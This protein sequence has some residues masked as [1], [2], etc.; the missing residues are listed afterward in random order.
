MKRL[1]RLFLDHRALSALLV[2]LA[3][4]M[5]LLVPAGFMPVVSGGTITVLLCDGTG[6]QR[7]AIS[8]PMHAGMAGMAHHGEDQ[9]KQDHQGKDMPCAFSGLSA[10]SMA[11]ADPLLLA[12]AIAF[13]VAIVF[14]RA[15]PIA[16]RRRAHLRPPLRGPPAYA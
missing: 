13:V 12:L 10:P 16:V 3:L 9:K 2:V 1:R 15:T 4:S 8:M 7:M 14:R 6:P 11:G 5:K